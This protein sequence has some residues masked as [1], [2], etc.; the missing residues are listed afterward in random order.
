MCKDFRSHAAGTLIGMRWRVSIKVGRGTGSRHQ[1]YIALRIPILPLSTHLGPP[2]YHNMAL[3]SLCQNIPFRSLPTPHTP[4]GSISISDNHELVELWGDNNDDYAEPKDPLGFPWHESLDALAES[5]KSG[6]QICVLVQSGAQ[7]WIDRYRQ[8]E[9]TNKLWSEY[10]HEM[11]HGQRLWL[12][13]RFA[14]GDGFVVMARHPKQKSKVNLLTG[15]AFSVEAASPLAQKMPLRPIAVDSG[16]RQSL[17]VAASWLKNCIEK[18][19]RCP[20]EDTSLPSRILDVGMSGDTIRLIDSTATLSGKYA[21]L[22]HCW[23]CSSQPF[24]TTEES[25]QA[26]LSGIRLSDLPKTF[27]DAVTITRY[28]AIRYLWIDSLCILQDDQSDWARES[29]RMTDVYS[30]AYLTLAVNHAKSPAEGCFHNRT[31]SLDLIN[32]PEIGEVHAQLSLPSEEWWGIGEF[33]SEPL[34]NRGWALQERVLANRL[35][36]YNSRHMYFE[37]NHGIVG[38]DGCG[39]DKRYCDLTEDK[40]QKTPSIGLRRETDTWNSLIWAYGQRELTKATDKL[41]AISGLARL[42]ETP[43]SQ[44]VAGLW[45]S[46]FIEGL[47][48]QCLGHRAPVSAEEYTG[49]SWSWASYDGIAATGLQEGWKDIAQIENWQADLK[50]EENPYGEVENAWIRIHAPLVELRPSTTEVTDHEAKL[51]GADIT[52]Y[53]R[54]CNPYSK[55]ED[56]TLVSLDH[57]DVIEPGTWLEWHMSVLILG[58]YD[59]DDETSQDADATKEGAEM[60]KES[61]KKNDDTLKGPC[62]GLVLIPSGDKHG[63]MKRVGWMFLDGDEVAKIRENQQYWKTVTIV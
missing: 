32:I 49:P 10:H 39:S 19:E 47:T 28:L 9:K 43:G 24:T 48:W 2:Y 3:C 1:H 60:E 31:T 40:K 5:A 16:S 55:D 51:I 15:V 42:F 13:Q 27:R 30:K 45:S 11:P 38:E 37:C 20:T 61:E 21:S 4:A 18:H 36:H 63:S 33:K 50:N 44:Y 14:G 6:C 59:E 8:A 57:R 12:R 62:Y 7:T 34:T 35:L 25:Y 17:D 29:S 46:S 56:G 53:P 52:P 41:P 26:R 23:G 58:G 54:L 22:S